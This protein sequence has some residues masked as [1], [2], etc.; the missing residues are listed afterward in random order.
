MTP[1]TRLCST[2]H[3]Q[4]YTRRSHVC[5]MQ[6]CHSVIKLNGTSVLEA[7]MLCSESQCCSGRSRL[8]AAGPGA[9]LKPRKLR[10]FAPWVEKN[11]LQVWKC[12]PPPQKKKISRQPHPP[13]SVSE[14]PRVGSQYRHCLFVVEWFA[15]NVWQIG[16][17]KLR[18]KTIKRHQ[19]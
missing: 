4:V 9:P 10:N 19:H 11:P 1:A 3:F 12:R 14:P 6:G 8:E 17:T 16:L 15:C 2:W 13:T 18:S 5:G 7:R